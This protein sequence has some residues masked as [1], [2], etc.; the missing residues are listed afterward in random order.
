MSASVYDLAVGDVVIL[1]LGDRVPADCI[2]IEST[3]VEVNES[4]YNEGRLTQVKKEVCN[5]DNF[6]Q[7]PDPFLK[8]QSLLYKGSCKALV[9]AVGSYSCREDAEG[10]LTMMGLSD[11][12]TTLQERLERVSIQFTK[13]ALYC[14]LVITVA[15]TV[16]LIITI[17]T[18]PDATLVVGKIGHIL[19]LCIAILIVCIPEGLPIAVQIALAYSVRRMKEEMV[20]VKNI[21]SLEIMGGVEEI[22]TGKTAT[23]T[24]NEMTV[25]MFYTQQRQINNSKK[26]TFMNSELFEHVT[27]LL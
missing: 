14:S 8:S 15:A 23:L 25:N 5:E 27:K 24:K 6:H 18:G 1:E 9:A 26:N 22:C 7:S 2:L 21:E 10:D 20:L 4:Y 12:K 19:T 16:H 11:F 13:Y 17:M 3:D